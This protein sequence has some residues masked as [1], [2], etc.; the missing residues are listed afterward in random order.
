[1]SQTEQPETDAEADYESEP[2]TR[3]EYI[4]A[5]V[6]LYR[7]ELHRSNSWRLRLDHTTNW[8]VITTA[9]L[10]TFSF[11]DPQHSHWTLLF[12]LALIS[13]FLGFEARRFRFAHMWRSR[14]RMIEENFYGPILRR[15]LT[16]PENKWGTLVADD[17]FRPRFKISRMAALRTRVVRN[18]WAIYSVILLA[19]VVKIITHP[20]SIYSLSDLRA[21]LMTGV[22]PWWTPLAY[23]GTFLFAVMLLVVFGPRTPRNELQY[24]TEDDVDPD[25]QALIDI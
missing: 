6:H 7:G 10:L 14:V 5:M 15:D 21:R 4:T 19:W 1:M 3:T 20:T 17:L 2:L 11:N 12:G 9:G 18:Y 13:V 23:V 8:S 25:D 22:L 24:W 16:S